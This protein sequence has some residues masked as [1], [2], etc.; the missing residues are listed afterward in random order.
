VKAHN[1]PSTTFHGLRHIAASTMLASNGGD[2][3]ATSQIIGHSDTRM[4]QKT[5]GHL[6]NAGAD[7]INSLEALIGGAVKAGKK[8]PKA[9]KRARNKKTSGVLGGTKKRR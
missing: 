9:P 3:W 4:L 5:Y 1:L 7:T 8:A 6:L 2:L